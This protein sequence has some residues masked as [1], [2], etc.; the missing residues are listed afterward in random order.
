MGPLLLSHGRVVELDTYDN[1][2]AQAVL[3]AREGGL[4][5]QQQERR[6]RLMNAISAAAFLVAAGRWRRSPRGSS[7]FSVPNLAIVLVVWL[8]VERVKFPVAGYWTLPDDARVRAGAVHAAGADRPAV[9]AV[10]ICGRAVP[11]S[12]G[13]ESRRRCS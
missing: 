5:R 8:L 2:A 11:G 3:A 13:A 9:A 12:S 10:A 6:L 1:P 4:E 7:R